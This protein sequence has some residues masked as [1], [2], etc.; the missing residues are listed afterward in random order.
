LR[1]IILEE[2]SK[3]NIVTYALHTL[4]TK[5]P[6]LFPAQHTDIRRADILVGVSNVE[7]STL[8]KLDES[9][10]FLGLTLNLADDRRETILIVTTSS[11]AVYLNMF[12]LEG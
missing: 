6:L 11:R 2:G 12:Y 10:F 3:R 5:H 4:F 9:K 8:K 1:H 7:N